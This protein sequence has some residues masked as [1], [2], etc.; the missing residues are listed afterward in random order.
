MKSF[1]WKIPGYLLLFLLAV[2]LMFAALADAE[3][4]QTA[5][6]TRVVF[7]GEY[8]LEDGLWQPIGSGSIRVLGRSVTLRGSFFAVS[9]SGGDPTPLESGA[10]I[11]LYLDHL[12]CT[13][14]TTENP[15]YSME[16][17]S[18]AMGKSGCAQRWEVYTFPGS[19]GPVEI[20]LRNPHRYGNPTG[21]SQLLN[22]LYLSTG[23]IPSL[24][25]IG[26][27]GFLRTMGVGISVTAMIL[28]GVA[29]FSMLLNL[30][31]SGILWLVGMTVL[32]AG[33]SY[34]LNTPNISLWS[35]LYQFNTTGQ[36]LSILMYTLF[37]QRLVRL[38]LSDRLKALGTVVT[39]ISSLLVILT[40]TFALHSQIKIYDL[41]GHWAPAEG[42]ICL[43][44]LVL[45]LMSF[46]PADTTRRI[47]LACFSAALMALLA[48]MA[49]A[50]FGWWNTASGSSVIF[51]LL[52]VL[53][54]V[55]VLYVL[56]QSIY[57]TFR[58]QRLQADLEKSRTAITLSQIQPHFLY[59]SLGAIRE[60]CRQ[61][62]EE[63]REALGIF[64]TYLRGN[65]DALKSQRPIH[66]SKELEHIRTYLYLEQMRFGD[67]LKVEY[68]IQDLDFFLPPLTVQPLVENA[69]KHG[70]CGKEEGGTVTL[71]TCRQ[72]NQVV[73]TVT[74]TGAGFD[75][76]R[77]AAKEH[78]GVSGV[79]FRV[80][81]LSQGKLELTSSPGQGTTATITLPV[82]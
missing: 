11:A 72:K 14:Q 9:K 65:M 3:P 13:I 26:D 64:V 8:C 63:A 1:P 7:Q 41:M 53:A 28:I 35:R 54:L 70:I 37:L 44:L 61:N 66:F 74:D 19:D 58:H 60:L 25:Q 77:L 51:G 23:E 73:I 30:K 2:A 38:C 48:D 39:R 80:E 59:N 22:N 81:V 4:A 76:T 34:I 36:M 57:A 78:V 5:K 52:L 21:V 82:N 71:T 16:T 27:S 29:L 79:R 20:T 42:V 69:V 62:P 55:A 56:P 24:Q 50:A 17:E 12:G 18:P 46:S 6:L 40:M 15:P 31:E 43:I 10:K 47:L 33:C 49:S 67:D 32:F 68:D 75:P 45:C